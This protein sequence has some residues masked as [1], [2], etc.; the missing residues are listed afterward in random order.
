[1][2]TIFI[3]VIKKSK[4]K[5]NERTKQEYIDA[6]NK[7][8]SIA[9]MCRELGLGCFG[10]NYRRIHKAIKEYN[11]DTSHF[12]GQAWNVGKI[13]NT[14]GS[15]EKPLEEI[16]V[17]HSTYDNTVQL[18]FKLFCSGLKE[19]KCEN[20][21]CGLT[22]WHGKPIPL[23][24]H[25]INGIRDDNRIENLQILCPNCH[26]LTDNFAGKN[27]AKKVKMTRKEKFDAFVKVHGYESAIKFFKKENKTKIKKDKEI[28]YCVVCGNPLS[29]R[30]RICCC[31]DCFNKYQ[32]R[33]MLSSKELS[34]LIDS[35]L[36][37]MEIAKKCNVTEAS[38][39]KWRRKYDI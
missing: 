22:E 37:N 15:K 34:E 10:A 5:K 35:G 13:I 33:R 26:A 25:H 9:G 11:I 4:M 8:L 16:L 1:M 3:Y 38:I 12:T 14:Y 21:E 6:A 36:S 28:R 23:Q 32:S 30:Q 7:S 39:R 24:L 19:Q 29:D 2:F 31:R 27:R 20:P 18:K 17:E